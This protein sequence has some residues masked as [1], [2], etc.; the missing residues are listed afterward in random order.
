VRIEVLE[1]LSFGLLLKTAT[2][3]RNVMPASSESRR[4]TG[5]TMKIGVLRSS[6]ACHIYK[7][8]PCNIPEDNLQAVFLFS[9]KCPIFY[10]RAPRAKHSAHGNSLTVTA[11][12]S[13]F[14]SIHPQCM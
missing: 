2:F 9:I 10:R 6:E 7:P 14:F 11:T 4:V 3:R 13:D 8:T 5:L 1:F 12:V